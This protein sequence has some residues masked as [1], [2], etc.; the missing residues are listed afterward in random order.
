MQACGIIVGLTLTHNFL[1]E[2]SGLI[3]MLH[4]EGFCCSHC[5]TAPPHWQHS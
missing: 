1:R 2:L 4:G 5:G 3:K